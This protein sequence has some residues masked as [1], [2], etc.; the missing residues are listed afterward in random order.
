MGNDLRDRRLDQ[1]VERTAARP[2]AAG[3]VS[4]VQAMTFRAAL[5]GVG[6]AVLLQLPAAALIA[7]RT[8]WPSPLVILYPLAK[9]VTRW[10][11]AVLGLTFSWGVP[12]GWTGA[13]TGRSATGSA[14]S[15]LCGQCSSGIRL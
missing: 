13:T 10:P 3:T 1:Q 9:R 12:L 7:G 8:A 2:L 14:A 5:C 6:L 4:I 11:Q 15:R